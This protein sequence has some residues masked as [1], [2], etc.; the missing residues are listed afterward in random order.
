MEPLPKSFDWREAK[1][2]VVGP[3]K[4][5]GMCGSC[6]AYGLMEPIES[7]RAVQT[8]QPLVNLPEQFAV[9]CTW[10]NGTGD[11][12][13]NFGCDGGDSDIGALEIVR[14]YGGIIPSAKAYGS[15][16]SI[17]GH[18]KDT[19]LMEVGAKITGWVDVKARDTRLMEVGAKI[20]GWVD[21]K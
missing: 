17:N 18:C 14:K 5:Q 4:D 1:P 12:G 20:T 6:W 13:G 3:V 10:T 21:V 2:G 11:S 16:L 8:G 19:R 7:I 15:Y 9:D